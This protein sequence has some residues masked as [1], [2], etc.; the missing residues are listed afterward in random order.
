MFARGDVS[1]GKQ[2]HRDGDVTTLPGMNEA[3]PRTR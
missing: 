1:G 2:L 3:G